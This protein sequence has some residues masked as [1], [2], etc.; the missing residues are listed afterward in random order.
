MVKQEL[1]KRSPL[2]ILEKS[3]HGGVGAGNIGVIA[4]RKGTGKTACLVHIATDQLFQGK[5]VIHI[6]FSGR[7]DHII[8]WYEDIFSEIARLRALDNVMEVH[9]E[10][11][12]NRVVMN[13][14]QKGVK[15][16]Q[17]LTSVRSLIKEGKFQA[18][19]IVVD[20]YDFEAGTPETLAA[21]E[22]FAQELGLSVWFSASIHRDDPRT[23]ENGVPMILAPY[24]ESVEVLITLQPNEDHIKFSL[25]K[26][27]DKYVKEDLHL[28]L[29][30]K[31]LLIAEE[32]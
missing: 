29:D 24:L 20:G 22:T 13:F 17:L 3:I 2:R 14:N 8:S 19:V 7:T 12:Q 30:P 28:M 27:H 23:D 6:S 21:I 25:I 11:I 10:L 15:A 31:S 4:G 9:D 26:D 16:E 32:K 5:H 18:D 1:I